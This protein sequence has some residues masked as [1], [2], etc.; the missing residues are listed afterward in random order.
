[1]HQINGFEM[2][3]KLGEGGMATVWQARQISLDRT[4]AIKILSDRF[5]ARSDD[6]RRFQEEAQAA[7]KLKH[8][9]IV[10][11]HD[12]HAE[13]GIYY[14]VMEF[15]SG[16]TVGD[17]VRRKGVLSEH[18]ALSVAECVADALDYAWERAGII[19]C[20][21]KPDNVIIDEDGT[22]KVADLGLARTIGAMEAASEVPTEVMGTPAY[23]SPEQA[24]GAPNLDF[25]TD[26][27]SL[28]AMLYHLV[29]GKMMFQG[30]DEDTTLEK[31]IADT[32]E[33]PIDMKPTLSKG[34]CW[35][36]ERM[37]AKDPEMREA[38]W[39]AVAEDILRVRRGLLPEGKVLPPDSS[40]VRRSERRS[41][42]D[43][44][45]VVRLQKIAQAASTPTMRTALVTGCI[46]VLL[47]VAIRSYL[48]QAEPTVPHTPQSLPSETPPPVQQVVTNVVT[49]VT[50][51]VVPE[52]PSVSAEPAEEDDEA[53]DMYE[54]AAAAY[55][56][57]PA[58]LDGAISQFEAVAR[59]TQG[60]K[61]TL[62]AQNHIREILALRTEAVREVSQSLRRQ[63]EGLADNQQF[64]KAIRLVVSYDGP[65][66]TDIVEMRRRILKRLEDA[67]QAWRDR[68]QQIA[69]ELEAHHQKSKDSLVMVI[70]S[71]DMSLAMQMISEMMEDSAFRGELSA[72]RQARDV[73]AAASEMDRRVLESFEAQ[74]GETV[75]VQLKTGSRTLTIGVVRGEQ[76]ECR[77]MLS[78]GRGAMSTIL[79]GISDLSMRE[80]LLRMGSDELPEVALAK[81]IMAFQSRAYSHAEKYFAM[82][83][84]FLSEMLL[85]RLRGDAQSAGTEVE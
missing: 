74:R 32:V 85:G 7:A 33:D 44:Q 9:G 35:L 57:N 3:G 6:V 82:T 41:L 8:P 80:R 45:R 34:I 75:D 16:Y 54:F 20:D 62:M 79:V 12:A 43:Y 37:T 29:T 58:D 30:E 4:V 27:Y 59:E 48:H 26:I 25:R 73:L 64:D 71:D 47:A 51:A 1:M 22:V 67:R 53:R 18:D 10:Q 17:W 38:S 2:I 81:G 5:S 46:A 52:P 21:I 77:Q 19:H 13:H 78:V 72:L 40:T 56:E 14:F 69:E 31:Q 39:G 24:Q 83:Q 65:Y 28:G 15:V 23:M 49:A 70:L 11:V 60:T 76:V 42:A 55:A 63:A 61:Y 36:I 50:E 84:P 66:A 68:Q